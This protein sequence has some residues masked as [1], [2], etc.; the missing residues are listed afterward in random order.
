M[1]NAPGR[2]NNMAILGD[3]LRVVALELQW[4]GM[5]IAMN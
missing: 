1:L 5:Q 3:L 2:L 4:V